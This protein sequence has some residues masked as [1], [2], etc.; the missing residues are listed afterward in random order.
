MY[1]LIR[2]FQELDALVVDKVRA[3]TDDK[4]KKFLEGKSIVKVIVIKGK[5]VNIVIK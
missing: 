2:Y 1:L 5:I 3:L 4:V